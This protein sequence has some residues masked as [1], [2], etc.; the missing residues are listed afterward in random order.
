MAVELFI[1]GAEGITLDVDVTSGELFWLVFRLSPIAAVVTFC[2]GHCQY[3]F[4]DL[5][6]FGCFNSCIALMYLCS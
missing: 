2:L 3:L 6:V 4:Q 1:F 5:V